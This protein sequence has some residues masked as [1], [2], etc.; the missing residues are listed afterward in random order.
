MGI[1]LAPEV[2]I[3]IVIA[4]VLFLGVYYFLQIYFNNPKKKSEQSKAHLRNLLEGFGLEIPP[5]LNE[6]DITVVDNLDT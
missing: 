2:Y 4:P 5:E 3:P 6:P 1:A